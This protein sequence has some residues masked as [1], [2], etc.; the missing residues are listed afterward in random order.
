[1]SECQ[2]EPVSHCDRQLVWTI[3]DKLSQGKLT[4]AIKDATQFRSESYDAGYA[5]GQTS[6]KTII[7]D[8]VI[9]CLAAQ[10]WPPEDGDKQIDEVVAAIMAVEPDGIPMIEEPY[11]SLSVQ[12][13]GRARFCRDRGEI[14]T[15]DLLEEAARVLEQ[16]SDTIGQ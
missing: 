15:P 14:K 10:E 13:R 4:T 12:L 11:S 5:D 7:R 1:M 2:A 8:A 3:A 16:S 9:T 6:M